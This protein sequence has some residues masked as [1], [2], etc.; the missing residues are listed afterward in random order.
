V[1]RV[2]R[3]AVASGKLSAQQCRSLAAELSSIG[4]LQSIADAW[5]IGERYM[6]LDVLQMLARSSTMHAGAYLNA[7]ISPG[8]IARIEPPFAYFFIPIPFEQ[9]MRA[10][11][12]F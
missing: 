12:H 6:G 4:E 11:N 1:C 2:E 8:P 5:N 3:A 7:A 9:T 10:M